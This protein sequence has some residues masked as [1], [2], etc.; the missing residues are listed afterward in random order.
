MKRNAQNLLEYILIFAMVAIVGYAFVSHF[1]MTNIR[2]YIFKRPASES[3]VN[4]VTSTKINIEAMT[5]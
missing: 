4:G 3:T 5:D 1:N 2:N